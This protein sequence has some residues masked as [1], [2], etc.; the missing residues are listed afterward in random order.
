MGVQSFDERLLERLGRIHSREQVFRSYAI[1][2]GAGFDNI[3]IDLMFGIPTQ[4]MEVWR[5]TLAEAIALGTQHLS[6]YEVIYEQDTPLL[7]QLKAGEF[8]VNL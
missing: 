6:C 3:N 5:A 8:D 7:E 1:L 2:R 4:T